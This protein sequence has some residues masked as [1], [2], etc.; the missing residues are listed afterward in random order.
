MADGSTR[1]ATSSSARP[2][3]NGSIHPVAG[4]PCHVCKW[5]M[6]TTT[7]TT[8]HGCL[9]PTVLARWGSSTDDFS[10]QGSW[11]TPPAGTGGS[12]QPTP[13]AGNLEAYNL[14]AWGFDSHSPGDFP[15]FFANTSS[16][17]AVENGTSSQPINVG[18]NTNG[19]DCARTEKRLLWTKE[20]DLRLV[21]AWLNNSNDPIQSNYR[22]NE[23]YWKEVAAVYNSTTPKNRARLVKHVKDRFA[24]IKKK[25][26]WF[27]ASWKEANALYASGESE[28]DLKKRAMQTYEEDHKED[29]PFMFHH[30]WEVLKKEPKWDAYLERLEDLEPEKRKFSVDDEVGKHFTLDDDRDE[31]PPGGKQAKEQRKR[32]RKGESCIIDLDD[33]LSKFVDAQTAANEGRKEMLE[34]Q[35]RV[36]S[37]NLEARKLACVAAKDR[38]ESVMLETYRSLMMQDTTQMPEDMDIWKSLEK[39]HSEVI[40][41]SSNDESDKM[42][43]AMSA[44]ASILHEHNASRCRSQS[45]T[46]ARLSSRMRSLRGLLAVS[47]HITGRQTPSTGAAASPH[48]ALFVRALQILSQPEPVRLHKLSAADTGIVELRLERPEARNAIG[49]EMLRGLRSAMDKVEADPTANVLLLASSVPKAFC[50]GADLKERRLMGLC[51]VREFVNSLRATFSSFE[52]LPIPTIAVIEGAAFGGGLELALSCDLRICGESATFCLPETGLAIIP[53]AGGTQRLP[54]IV[55]RSRAKELIFTGRRFDATEAVTMGVVNYCVPGGEAYQKALELAREI[56]GK[57]P[58][59]IRM[60]KKAINQGMEVDLSSA[61]TVEEECYEQVLHTQDRLEGLAAFAEKRKPVYTGK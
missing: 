47:G 18:D 1:P 23:Q 2:S 28:V 12:A 3:G 33:E 61:L 46:L 39:F 52:A 56:N 9:L 30:C 4:H 27:C 57:G 29:D 35:R 34:T 53:G 45:P 5:L 59:A 38:K 21:S 20:E 6:V 25:V 54:R 31:R 13:P 22:K 49:K 8:V 7:T 37:E 10:A 50:A 44:A 43:Q 14:Q 51:E 60:A 11:W 42:T 16:T 32:K 41:S 48:S 24:K 15:S 17:Q 26:A 19:D 55:G 58:L 36:S 40:D